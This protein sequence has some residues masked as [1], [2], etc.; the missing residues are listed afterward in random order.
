MTKHPE[1]DHLHICQV[2]VGEDEP[3][4]IVCGAP[5]VAADQRLLLPYQIPELA[6]TLNQAFKDAWC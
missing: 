6:A 1:S 2:D 3:L 5:N 4:Q